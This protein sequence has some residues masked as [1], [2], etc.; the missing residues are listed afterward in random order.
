MRSHLYSCFEAGRLT[1]FPHKK[2]DRSCAYV[3][4]NNDDFDVH[5]HC[6]MPEMKDILMIECK[7]CKKWFHVH[8]EDVADNVLEQSE[9]EW[10]CH[11]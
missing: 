2:L 7:K 8:C 4:R 5:C 3:L 10:F 9:S 11:S 6:R 1:P